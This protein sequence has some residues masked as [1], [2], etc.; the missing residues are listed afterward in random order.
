MATRFEIGYVGIIIFGAIFLIAL[1]VSICLAIYY[2][3]VFKMLS[4]KKKA[5]SEI[6]SLPVSVTGNNYNNDELIAV[7]SAAVAAYLSDTSVETVPLM[8]ADT[9]FK[10]VSFRKVR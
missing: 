6:E 9:K 4:G 7:I 8:K 1:I 5:E 10:V 3:P 2:I